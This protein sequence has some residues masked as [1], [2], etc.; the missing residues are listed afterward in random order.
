MDMREANKRAINDLIDEVWRKGQLDALPKFWTADC[1][2]HADPAPDK[3]GLEAIRKYHE[4][5]AY[6]FADFNDIA[7]EVEQQ[8]AENDRVVT[9]LLLCALHKP[10]NRRISLATIRIDRMENER[11]AEHWSVADMAGLMKQLG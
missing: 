10:T 11:I 4:G 8:V 5:F 6:W 9:Q 1:L 2:N 3:R 7:I